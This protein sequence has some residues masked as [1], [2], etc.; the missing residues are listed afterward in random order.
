[1]LPRALCS[2]GFLLLGGCT[3]PSPLS[4]RA[5]KGPL[6]EGSRVRA[7]LLDEDYDPLGILDEVETSS[8][9][10]FAFESLP[11]VPVLLEAEGRFV[12]ERTG[13]ETFDE[14]RLH[15]LARVG[16]NE[17]ANVNALTHIVTPYMLALLR[18][19]TDFDTAL[20]EAT[21][22]LTTPGSFSSANPLLAQP[23]GHGWPDVHPIEADVLGGPS[24]NNAYL[25]GLSVLVVEHASSKTEMPLA[26]AA[27]TLLDDIAAD[28]GDDG[29]LETETSAPLW[30]AH[31]DLDVAA[32]E[33]Q[34]ARL[35]AAHG[36][37]PHPP[38]LDLVL[39]SDGD[40]WPNASDICP[41]YAPLGQTA[42]L[43]AYVLD[44]WVS[45][46]T[47]DM[48]GDGVCNDQDACPASPVASVPSPGC[49]DPR[50]GCVQYPPP[51]FAS[52]THT[53]WCGWSPGS[54]ECV[55]CV[56]GCLQYLDLRPKVCHPATK[57]PGGL[58]ESEGHC[59]GPP[60]WAVAYCTAHWCTVGDDECAVN[61]LCQ[62]MFPPERTRPPFDTLGVCV[63]QGSGCSKVDYGTECGL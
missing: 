35:Y 38:D 55:D 50:V 33:R 12:D 11:A 63:E 53:Q 15:S 62:P 4:G 61:E 20:A 54:L 41:D 56:G 27:Q 30:L 6:V 18:E 48:D 29:N 44:G 46:T 22:A 17:T 58:C 42:Q 39:T 37:W 5:Q 36:L 1:M 24:T 14:V 32:V 21:N 16:A 26:I 43:W 34:V 8:D 10:S 9:G 51:G 3:P 49:C 60:G 40:L 57:A 59:S 23:G 28:L 31:D 52:L 13:Q 19:G 47:Q 45:N 2:V 7:Y 25:L